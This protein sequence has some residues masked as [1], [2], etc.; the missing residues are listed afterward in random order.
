MTSNVFLNKILSKF[1]LPVF[2]GVYSNNN[3]PPVSTLRGKSIIVNTARQ[4]SPG[5]HFI[6]LRFSRNG[7]S[8]KVYDS[9]GVK[10]CVPEILTSL[11][12]L[13]IINSRR[14]IQDPFSFYCG[15]FAAGIV[16]LHAL[17][18]PENYLFSRYNK[19]NLRKNDK[20]IET[21]IIYCINRLKK[22]HVN[23]Q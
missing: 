20:I 9:F 12:G 23:H 2:G 4:S 21:F 5:E 3:I 15:Y 18:L 7:Q 22:K 8:V 10:L 19:I 17:G 13:R 16:F 6:T 11:K 1:C 14:T